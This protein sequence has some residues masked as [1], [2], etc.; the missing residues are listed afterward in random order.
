MNI[1]INFKNNLMQ[2]GEGDPSLPFGQT[3]DEKVKR[4][5]ANIKVAIRCR[6]PLENEL[7]SNNTFEKLVVSQTQ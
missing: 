4:E 7:K 2:E 6:P 5:A 1:Y 3:M